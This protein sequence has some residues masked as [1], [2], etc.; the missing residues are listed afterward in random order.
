MEN[1]DDLPTDRTTRAT[2]INHAYHELAAR[3]DPPLETPMNGETFSDNLDDPTLLHKRLLES[4]HALW[5]DVYHGRANED[6]QQHRSAVEF[7]NRQSYPSDLPSVFRAVT[8]RTMPDWL[9]ERASRVKEVVFVPGSHM[10]AHFTISIF[11]KKWWVGFNANLVPA[12]R[13]NVSYSPEMYPA[14]KALADE[15][16]LKIVA[17][18]TEGEFNV[19]EIAEALNLT[20]IDGFPTS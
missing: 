4:F 8:G 3:W 2:L 10:G 5:T 18:L 13:T 11:D 7:H 14:L 9:K 12:A 17:L 6:Q 16:R 20:T 19:G 15:T 1:G